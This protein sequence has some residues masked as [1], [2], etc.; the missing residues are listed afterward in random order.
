MDE[1]LIDERFYEFKYTLCVFIIW[2][3]VDEMV[4]VFHLWPHYD[5]HRQKKSSDPCILLS[6]AWLVYYEQ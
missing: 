1:N 3:F 4:N 6:P 5:D 2:V